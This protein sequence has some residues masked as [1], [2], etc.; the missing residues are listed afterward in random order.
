MKKIVFISIV[1]CFF[2]WVSGQEKPQKQQ[3]IGSNITQLFTTQ[4]SV[5]YSIDLVSYFTPY[6][7]IGYGINVKNGSPFPPFCDCDND[8]YEMSRI[9]GGYAKLGGF[10]NIRKNVQ[11][12]NYFTLGMFVTNSMVYEKG[13][14]NY[15]DEDLSETS[16]PVSHKKYIAAFGTSVGYQFKMGKRFRSSVNF[17][18]S[19][20]DKK[21]H[22]LYGYENYIPGIGGKNST[23]CI[24]PMLIWNLQYRLR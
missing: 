23:G 3:Y 21:H 12:S 7:E 16:I 11:K 1:L 20:P 4:L 22:D 14:Y 13:I 24:F 18:L 5:N 15:W 19:F 17:Q 8:G 6:A 9:S 10:L 2:L